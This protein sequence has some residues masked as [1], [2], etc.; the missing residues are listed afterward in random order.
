MNS[1]IFEI[2]G[3]NKLFVEKS[4]IGASKHSIL[5]DPDQHPHI[6]RHKSHSHLEEDISDSAFQAL[7]LIA[8]NCD[9]EISWDKHQKLVK[10]AGDIVIDFENIHCRRGFFAK[11]FDRM[12]VT[13][14]LRHSEQE[15][16]ILHRSI[17][18]PSLGG[19]ISPEQAE[20]LIEA[21]RHPNIS[22]ESYDK[23]ALT[24]VF[25][26][27]KLKKIITQNIEI[28]KLLKEPHLSIYKAHLKEKLVKE[29]YQEELP[30][31]IHEGYYYPIVIPMEIEK[32][33]GPVVKVS[34]MNLNNDNLSHC[35]ELE[36]QRYSKH[37]TKH[38]LD[39]IKKDVIDTIKL[40]LKA[41]PN[42][43]CRDA[44]VLGR[45]LIR[46]AVYQEI[47]DK[48][49]FSGSDHGSKHIHNNIENANSLHGNMQVKV[50]Y[51]DK[52]VF[53]E[54]LIHFYH[55]IGYT[56]GLASKSFS[57][58]KDHP[59]IG[60]KMI[61]ENRDY[62]EHYLD[63]E[64]TDVLWNGVLLH[65]IAMPNLTP[66]TKAIGG[67]YPGMVRAITSI[68]DACAVT[69]DR[70]TQEFWEQPSTL[71]ALARLR[72]FLTKYPQYIAKLAPIGKSEWEL[73]DKE[74]SLD[75]LAHDVFHHTKKIL[76]KA[77]DKSDVPLEKKELFR[78]AILQQ[79][80]SFTTATTLGQFGGILTGVSAFKNDE[81]EVDA[82]KFYPQFDMAP[83]LIYGTLLDLFGADIAQASFKKL[84][85]EFNGDLSLLSKEINEAASK[86]DGQSD[87][88]AKVIKTGNARFK[89]IGHHE[90]DPSNKHLEEMQ[91]ALVSVAEKVGSVSRS[92]YM[93]LSQKN[94]VMQDFANFRE[95]KLKDCT[96]FADFI[97]EYILPNL[98]IQQ[99]GGA[100]KDIEVLIQSINE[101]VFL[102]INRSDT[103][104]NDAFKPLRQCD[105]ESI[106]ADI[107]K[108]K[109]EMEK[110]RSGFLEKKNIAKFAELKEVLLRAAKNSGK[111][112]LVLFGNCLE[113][114]LDKIL[115]NKKQF[116]RTE[117][118]YNA[119]ENAIKLVLVSE[120]EYRFMRG[121]KAVVKKSE[122]LAAF[123]KLW[124]K[125]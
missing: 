63:K 68:S 121:K 66:D 77:V 122:C 89:I 80:N 17:K 65:A 57:C 56:V 2:K 97:S 34:R 42:K 27:D 16:R 83:S 5:L 115:A 54:R 94:C 120:E 47:F 105:F 41:Y 118:R 60:A 107:E 26:E 6:I 59:L 75:V 32:I 101:G 28:I 111:I 36:A 116:A 38:Q 73:L 31:R 71:I 92:Q 8:R 125:E 69:Y 62:F 109:N 12:M 24:G 96:S 50:D 33:L 52:D 20:I 19:S 9:E 76:L 102:E 1:S 117:K 100:V 58:C 84:V 110:M 108:F 49:S 95:G 39:Y 21:H 114:V 48:A 45:D 53:M 14:D 112:D 30:K 72:L 98:S 124:E 78:Q 51:N 64:S 104:W 87:F 37:L 4:V 74:N 22:S 29:V 81:T 119:I 113:E 70:K 90:I 23:I 93:S 123:S 25:F 106:R 10:L 99:A 85:D 67:M 82:P 103:I 13:F 15:I 43:S 79:F 3:N 40:Y 55:D 86:K 44:F 88:S 11:V 7:Q 61:E 18:A 46:I 35:F 91:Q